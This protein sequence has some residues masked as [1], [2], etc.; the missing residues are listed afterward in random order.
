[1]SDSVQVQGHAIKIALEAGAVTLAEIIAWAD[2]EIAQSDDPNDAVID[3]S[4]VASEN[5]ALTCLVKL[6]EGFEPSEEI[7]AEITAH[8][9]KQGEILQL[10][11][12]YSA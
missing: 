5:D 10:L 9:D 2:N 6:L 8:L 4:M 12:K 11:K 1:M 3:L 7:S